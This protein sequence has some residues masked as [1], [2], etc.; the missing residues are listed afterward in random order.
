MHS[1]ERNWKINKGFLGLEDAEFSLI[2]ETSAPEERYA[3]KL[4]KCNDAE[5]WSQCKFIRRGYVHLD[6][7]PQPQLPGYDPHNGTVVDLYI[8]GIKA[9]LLRV[10]ATTLRLEGIVELASPVL[11]DMDPVTEVVLTPTVIYL[12]VA[13]D[14]VMHLGITRDL[15]IV[16]YRTTL[17]TE[18][19][20]TAPD[21]TGHGDPT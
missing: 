17:F 2:R 18:V 9:F 4:T 15:L 21:G 8:K 6:W 1:W 12:L 11:N 5:T 14:A 10:S 3:M 19:V 7:A 13:K 16:V 20:V